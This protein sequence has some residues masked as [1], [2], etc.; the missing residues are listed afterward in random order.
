MA[1]GVQALAL[2]VDFRRQQKSMILICIDQHNK[3]LVSKSLLAFRRHVETKKVQKEKTRRANVVMAFK[4]LR[5]YWMLWLKYIED[6]RQRQLFKKEIDDYLREKTVR[7]VFTSLS[8][9][10]KK[11]L[12]EKRATQKIRSMI[13]NRLM[14]D[15]VWRMM[16][17]TN[18]KAL[19]KS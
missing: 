11:S 18:K 9:F 7:Q 3:H 19:L 8:I 16:S 10:Y 12:Q 5:S 1:K 17:K 2:R 4:T 14:R 15:V 13:N 6:R